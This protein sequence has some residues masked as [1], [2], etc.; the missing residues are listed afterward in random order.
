M[1]VRDDLELLRLLEGLGLQAQGPH[2][3]IGSAPE[4]KAGPLVA[5]MDSNHWATPSAGPGLA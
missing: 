2:R 4:L 5:E 3:S 1:D